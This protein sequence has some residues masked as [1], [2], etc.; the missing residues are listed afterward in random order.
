MAVIPTTPANPLTLFTGAQTLTGGLPITASGRTL[1]F[2]QVGEYLVLVTLTGTT[3]G[4][5]SPTLGGT[6]TS[7]MISPEF[8]IDVGTTVGECAI[9]VSVS[10]PA[11]TLLLDVTATFATCDSAVVRFCPYAYS[12]A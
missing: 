1:T 10:N 6:V 5:A 3:I 12:N 2:Y 7:A 8:M 9:R 11:Q 4:T